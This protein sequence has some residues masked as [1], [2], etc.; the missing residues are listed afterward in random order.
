MFEK[1]NLV[2]SLEESILKT[3]YGVTAGDVGF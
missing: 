3:V 2:L 1:K